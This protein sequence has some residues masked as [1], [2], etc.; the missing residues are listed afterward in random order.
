M[1]ALQTSRARLWRT[2]RPLRVISAVVATLIAI[3]IVVRVL[4]NAV[5]GPG[6]IHGPQS[7]SYST[8]DTGLA[9]FAELLT[10]YDHRV[11]RV[12]GAASFGSTDPDATLVVLDAPDLSAEQAQAL[13]GWVRRGGAL[14]TGGVDP[15]YL[16]RLLDRT[17][18]WVPFAPVD[19]DVRDVGS[20]RTA[21]G[22]GFGSF[23][24]SSFGPDAVA[25]AT[26]F[27]KVLVARIPLGAGQVTVL[28][29]S[30]P[31]SNARIAQAD[32]AAL[33]LGLVSTPAVVFAENVGVDDAGSVGFASLPARWRFAA[34]GCVA[35]VIVLLWALG[36]RFGP[37]EQRFRTLHPPRAEHLEAVATMLEQ[38][39]DRAGAIAS[40]QHAVQQAVAARSSTDDLAAAADQLGVPA[41]E[42][43]ATCTAPQS[44]TEVLAAGRALARVRNWE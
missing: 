17:P 14:V 10:R 8:D 42:F 19:W 22:G 36:R 39:A 4:D 30:S 43:A 1:T 6:Q 15:V 27:D 38:S 21:R 37:P 33:G 29:D 9:A 28:A 3:P 2:S 40:V 32:N 7:S 44:D 24:A 26:N 31:L 11:T 5:T 35:A 23:D 25:L 16:I 12:Q 13:G 20:A 41:D 34:L 18:T